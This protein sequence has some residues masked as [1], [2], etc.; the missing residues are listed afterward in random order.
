MQTA[1]QGLLY[2]FYKSKSM[3]YCNNLAAC[4][5][6]ECHSRK[7]KGL[8]NNINNICMT[9]RGVSSRTL[10]LC[11][12]AESLLIKFVSPLFFLLRQV[13]VSDVKKVYHNNTIKLHYNNAG[14]VCVV[15]IF[16]FATFP[17]SNA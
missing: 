14:T 7:S 3:L 6:L 10:V 8:I 11:M 13:K 4:S 1:L 9:L 16:P 15:G 12:L 2:L 17:A 5:I